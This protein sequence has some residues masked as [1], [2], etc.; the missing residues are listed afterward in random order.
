MT[1]NIDPTKLHGMLDLL[2]RTDAEGETS[3]PDDDQDADDTAGPDDGDDE[4]A[5]AELEAEEG[6]TGDIRALQRR[7]RH[8]LSLEEARA[9]QVRARRRGQKVGKKRAQ[10]KAKRNPPSPIMQYP[11]NMVPPGS[12]TRQL[13]DKW[14]RKNDP[15]VVR[16]D[17]H[18]YAVTEIRC[19]CEGSSNRAWVRI[20][21]GSYTFFERAVG[22]DI[23]FLGTIPGS[24]TVN[25]T[26]L[27]RPSKNTYNEQDF[28][29][30]SITMQEAGLRVRYDG[31]EVNAIPGIGNAADVLLGKA[32]LW[33]DA[34]AFLPKEIF[35]DFN[36]ENLLYRALRRSGVLF[37]RW[38]K[39]RTGGNGTMRQVL[40][41]HLRNVPDTKVKSLQR[42]SGGAPVLPVPDGYI[43]TDN[44]ER[45]EEGQ[46]SAVI[47]VNEDIAFPV[48]PIDIG[49]G[50]PS[51]PLEIGLYVQLSLNGVSF[52]HSKRAQ[53][54]S[55]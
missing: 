5:G 8:T 18:Y 28:L 16:Q 34:G 33:D 42:T 1:M 3:G 22:D 45:S 51:K 20:P 35:H 9:L 40:V 43:F 50:S 36:G 13:L 44:P 55:V 21:A 2:A 32:W 23:T 38:D 26:N 12:G 15:F 47:T 25:L 39:R 46:F 48:K 14:R 27:Q 29:I 19:I 24:V 11:P 53:G 7:G 10:V 4:V 49:A 6:D 41:D 52:E 31:G 54:A 30:R 37:F 17:G